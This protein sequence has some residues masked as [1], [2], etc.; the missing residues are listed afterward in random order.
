MKMATNTFTAGIPVYNGLGTNSF[1]LTFTATPGTN[2]P[3]ASF[4]ITNST[5]GTYTLLGLAIN[6]GTATTATLSPFQIITAAG[7]TVTFTI[8]YSITG[9]TSTSTFKATPTTG[10]NPANVT[11][12]T[13]LKLATATTVGMVRGTDVRLTIASSVNLVNCIVNGTTYWATS[14]VITIPGYTVTVVNATT[15]RLA[16]AQNASSSITFTQITGY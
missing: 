6:S 16:V 3:T 13:T 14:N 5:P 15:F 7:S 12:V 1:N 2:T 9:N 4:T 11:K 10:N 8:T